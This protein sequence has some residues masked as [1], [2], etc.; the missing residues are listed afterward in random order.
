M[1]QWL[2]QALVASFLPK[3]LPQIAAAAQKFCNNLFIPLP[4]IIKISS[5]VC[6]IY[7]DFFGEPCSCNIVTKRSAATNKQKQQLS[8]IKLKKKLKDKHNK[9][10]N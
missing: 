6:V 8:F 1:L 2:N 3:C 5:I 9:C 10:Q 4:W 7:S